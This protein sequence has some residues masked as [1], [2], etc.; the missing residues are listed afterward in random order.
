MMRCKLAVLGLTVLAC[1]VWGQDRGGWHDLFDG[2]T[3]EGWKANEQ[4]KSLRVEN[5]AIVCEGPRS[6]LFYAGAVANAEFGDFELEA[7]VMASPGANSGLYFHTRWQESD[8]PQQGFEVQVNNTATG[9]GGYRENKKTGSLYGIRNVYRQLVEDNTWFRLRIAVIGGQVAVHVNGVQTVRYVEPEGAPTG[10]YAG[11]RLGRGTFALQAHDPGSRVAFRA[12]RV[13]PLADAPRAGDATAYRIP[14]GL[15]E[16]HA[17][18]FPVIDLHTH[19]K[20][21]LTMADVVD[22]QFRTGINAGVA[23]N[24]GL[25]FAVTN[26][27]GIARVLAEFRHPLVY[28]AMQAEG[29]EWVDLFSPAAMAQFDY[30]FTDAMTVVDDAGRRMRLWIPGEV[31]VGQPEAFMEMLVDRTVKIL[32]REPVDVWVN[33]TYLPEVLAK[34]Y[35]RLWTPA[36]M[37]RVIAAAVKHGVAIEINDRFQ[38][39]GLEFIRRAKAA[40]VKFTFG[41]NNGGREDLGDL[42][43]CVRA[44]KECGLKWQDFW[45]PGKGP[46]RVQGWRKGD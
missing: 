8:W 6:H 34:D 13:R 35:G 29:R 27:A 4:G 40:G 9:E 16:L 23:L 41:T 5:G 31:A 12:I 15:A 17:N 44:V 32:E 45:V 14:A 46:G 18:N 30:V 19:L 39:P 20:G 22:R 2:R 1:S 38:L 24:C 7:E 36:R 21:G 26:D 28:T 43:Y 11:R 10:G 3:L 42:A 33:P 37:D 25:G